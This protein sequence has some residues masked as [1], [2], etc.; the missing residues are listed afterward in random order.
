MYHRILNNK[1]LNNI[2]YPY[3][4]IWTEEMDLLP[5]GQRDKCRFKIKSKYF[6]YSLTHA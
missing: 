6:C 4:G 5:K 1:K 3:Q 2:V